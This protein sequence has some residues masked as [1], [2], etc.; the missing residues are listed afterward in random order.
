[1]DP[2]RQYRQDELPGDIFNSSSGDVRNYNGQQVR[3]INNGNGTRT[4]QPL[5]GAGGG[6]GG[7]NDPIEQAKKIL[8]F[9]Q[10]ANQPAIQTLQ[11]EVDPLKK[12]YQDL[13]TSLKGQQTVAQNRQTLTTGNELGKRGLTNDSGLYQ[14]EMTNALLPVDTAYGQLQVQANQGQVQDL[15]AIQNAIAQLQ[16]GAASTAMPQSL[17]LA[18]IN[19]QANQFAQDLALRQQTANSENAYRQAQ[20]QAANTAKLSDRF[21]SIGEGSTLYDLLNGSAVYKNPK[22]YQAS[23]T[24]SS[25]GWGA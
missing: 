23:T 13:L 11:G 15:N 18:G 6:G 12:Q 17:Q 10:E 8:A 3:V 24:S 7:S 16:A 4:L 2:S 21:T 1:M 25:S 9:Q 20:I 5:G 19:N 22:T 14:Q